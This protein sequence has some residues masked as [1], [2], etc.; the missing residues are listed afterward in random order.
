VSDFS[1]SQSVS[2][3]QVIQQHAVTYPNRV[4]FISQNHKPILYGELRDCITSIAS[5]L[6]DAGIT[7]NERIAIALPNGLEAALAIVTVA[8]SAVAVPLDP[9]LTP[10]EIGE[11][12]VRLNIAAIILPP[13]NSSAR[14]AAEANDVALFTFTLNH[15]CEATL[16]LVRSR[17]C[18]QFGDS[19]P[20]AT[21]YILPTSGTTGRQKFVPIA[22]R[23]QIELSTRI[24]KCFELGPGDRCLCL[25]PVFYSHGLSMGVLTPLLSGGSVA[26]P[27]HL[28]NPTLPDWLAELAPTWCSG[29]P[30]I[31]RAMSERLAKSTFFPTNGLRFIVSAGM[32]LTENVRTALETAVGVPVLEHYGLTESGMMVTNRPSQHLRKPSTC[33]KAPADTVAI[34]G[35]D[36]ELLPPGEIGEILVRGPTVTCGYLDDPAANTNLFV[37]DWLRTGD[38]GCLDD[39]RFLTIR[40]RIKEVINSGGLKIMPSEIDA[41]LM[42]HPAVAEAAAFGLPHPRSGEQVAAAVVFRQGRAATATELREWLANGLAQYKIP[43]RIIFLESLPRALTGKVQRHKLAE[44]APKT[45]FNPRADGFPQD[46]AMTEGELAQ[47][48]AELLGR[49]GQIGLDDDSF[50]AVQMLLEVERLAGMS[51]PD[52]FLYKASTIREFAKQLGTFA[53]STR[54]PLVAVQDSGGQPPFFFC[55][56]NYL[57]GGYYTRRF[58]H[59]LGP[60]QPFYALPP[61]LLGNDGPPPSM[62]QLAAERVP[63]LLEKQPAGQ[64]RVGGYCNGALLAFEMARQL[65]DAGRKVEL[66]TMID[67]PSFNV[68]RHFRLSCA[69]FAGAIKLAGL[70][71]P[72]RER[73][74]TAFSARLGSL[75]GCAE[76]FV[77]T[78][79][80]E[81]AAMIERLL[82]ESRSKFWPSGQTSA[83][84]SSGHPLDVPPNG[85]AQRVAA[86]VLDQ[87]H[88]RLVSSYRPSPVRAPVLIFSAVHSA[89]P[90]RRFCDKISVV[91]LP[92][93]HLGWIS[94]D[95]EFIA[96]TVRT[97]LRNSIVRGDPIAD[98]AVATAIL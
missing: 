6:R 40:G 69:A 74:L 72:K 48:W 39:D 51:L 18:T 96:H 44:L 80:T 34:A 90:W 64:F 20:N 76:R 32:A 21:A 30:A 13:G 3:G 68:R 89:N 65:L 49:D 23:H 37:G 45:S 91:N 7:C 66:V 50:L 78:N 86:D 42:A 31:Y 2:L 11:R 41:Q 35:P 52:D 84:A 83:T 25:S 53:G 47:L 16:E 71:S 8:C 81:R 54:S 87:R 36:G 63:L 98:A 61:P 33:G 88:H 95:L 85:S 57:G 22:H 15:D 1:G 19:E 5:H 73:L 24:E 14:A 26:L 43:R 60:D 9:R 38:L 75:S 70:Q 97:R 77:R 79:R 58:A 67:P 94:T 56:G 93:D 27:A 17:A 10:A 12:L 62:E 29:G 92:P 4:A 46:Y 59:L 55:H 82:D 28:T